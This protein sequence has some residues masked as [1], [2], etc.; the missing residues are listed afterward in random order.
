MVYI[1]FLCLVQGIGECLPISSS[2]HLYLLSFFGGYPP[3][4]H[5]IEAILHLG[6]L[7]A[8]CAFLAKPL[9][10]MIK[11]TL[12]TLVTFRMTDGFAMS[13]IIV[14]AT[15]PAIFFGF[16]VKRYVHMPHT[17]L[18]I[19]IASV[20]FGVLLLLAD[21][22][23]RKAEGKVNL[24]SAMCIGFAQILAFIPGASRFG[25]CLTMARFL[26]IQRW[27]ATQFSFM[28]AIPTILGAVVLSVW[29]VQQAG[30]L[31]TLLPFVPAILM[32]VVIS[33]VVLY[34]LKWYVARYSYMPFAIYRILLGFG[35]IGFAYR[36]F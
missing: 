6:S 21:L 2:A 20:V 25:V 35:L 28:L 17:I 36:M 14:F 11:G 3:T 31:M 8:L 29:D 23:G 30:N 33:L 10:C 24:S 16:I 1:L 4:S 19:G 18:S 15:L 12:K 27:P 26:D 13:L 34:G 22:T 5:E 7:V 32:T 9:W